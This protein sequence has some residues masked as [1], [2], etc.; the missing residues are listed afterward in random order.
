MSGLVGYSVFRDG[1]ATCE[2]A[3]ARRAR[4]LDLDGYEWSLRTSQPGRSWG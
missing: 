2:R 3:V 1:D 4:V